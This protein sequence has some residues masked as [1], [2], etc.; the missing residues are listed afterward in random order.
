[1]YKGLLA[2][3]MG[4]FELALRYYDKFY[5]MNDKLPEIPLIL[6][7]INSLQLKMKDTTDQSE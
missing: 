1:M 6:K 7:K 2:E 5:K 4:F 3:K